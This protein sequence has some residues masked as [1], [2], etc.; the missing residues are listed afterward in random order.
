ML[1]NACF[2]NV[3]SIQRSNNY[4]ICDF[5]S[6]VPQ[7]KNKWRS[8]KD[9]FALRLKKNAIAANDDLAFLIKKE[10]GGTVEQ[11]Q[12]CEEDDLASFFRSIASTMRKFPPV[13]IALMKKLISDAVIGKEIALN[14]S[15]QQNVEFVYEVNDQAQFVNMANVRFVSEAVDT[16]A[17]HEHEHYQ[18]IEL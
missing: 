12:T 6:A 14:T 15:E 18:L 7:C 10:K 2:G 4:K 17:Q 13:D 5:Y 11:T 1:I 3:Q 8:L 9:Y 16:N